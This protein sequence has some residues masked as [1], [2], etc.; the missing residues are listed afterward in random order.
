MDHL[1]IAQIRGKDRPLTQAVTRFVA[2]RGAAGILYGS[3][4]DDQPC[5][6]LFE[7]R[8]RLVPASGYKP[9]KLTPDHP[10]LVAIC[11]ELGLLLT[12]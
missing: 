3:N 4:L 10:D 1:D 9:E 12:L 7:G 5:A 2:E 11:E 8:A 6:A